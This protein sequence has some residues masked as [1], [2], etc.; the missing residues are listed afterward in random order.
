MTVCL[1]GIAGRMSYPTRGSNNY[2]ILSSEIRPLR[3]ESRLYIRQFLP[4]DARALVRR[5]RATPS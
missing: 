5:L 4:G 1:K 2:W 3:E